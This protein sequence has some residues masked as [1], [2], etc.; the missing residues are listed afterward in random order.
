MTG[1]G[2]SAFCRRNSLRFR[3]EG[4]IQK[5]LPG[6][7]SQSNLLGYLSAFSLRN[8]KMWGFERKDPLTT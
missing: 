5:R 6:C 3:G 7:R 4:C 2:H 1:L 8:G